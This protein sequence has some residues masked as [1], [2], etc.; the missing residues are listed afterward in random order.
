MTSRL[1][2]VE[3]G[4]QQLE[5]RL[6]TEVKRWDERFF[7]LTRDTLNFT[8]NVLITAAVVVVLAPLL[9]ETAAVLVETLLAR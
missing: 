8:R 4:V 2:K 5:N 6:E 1:Q 9:R 7:Q 3:D